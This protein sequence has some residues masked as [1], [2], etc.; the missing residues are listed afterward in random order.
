MIDYIQAKSKEDFAQAAILF[1]EYAEWLNIDLSF[2]HFSEELSSLKS[3]Y[4]APVGTIILAKTADEYVGCI[5]VRKFEERIAE[6]KRMYVQPP[7]RGKGLG[8]ALLKIALDKARELGYKK[9][10]LD[11]LSHMTPAIALYKK[12]GFCEIPGYYPNPE[13]SAVYFE[14]NLEDN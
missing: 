1:R 7:H 3:M 14:K 6:L 5:A 10:R 8:D 9:I 11:T 4:A 13:K 12:Y 2:Q